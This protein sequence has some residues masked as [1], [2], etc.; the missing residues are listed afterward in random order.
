MHAD[1]SN[2]TPDARHWEEL[3]F[4]APRPMWIYDVN[5]LEFLAVN[6]AAV[7]TYGWSREEFHRMTI[8]DIRPKEDAAR[9][10]IAVAD[11]APYKRSGEWHHLW[12]DGTLRSVEITSHQ[13]EWD[14]R[15]ARLVIAEDVTERNEVEQRLRVMNEKLRAQAALLDMATDAIYVH[16]LDGRVSYWNRSSAEL[17]GWSAEEAVGRNIEELMGLP[18]SDLA[19]GMPALIR[20]GQK[21]GEYRARDRKGS[22]FTLE[23]R[24]TVMYSDDGSPYAILAIATDVTAQRKLESQLLRSQRLESIGTLAGGI[25]HDLNNMLSPIMMSIQLLSE[26][27]TDEGRELLKTIER[28]ARRG[29][30]LVRQVLAFARGMEGERAPVAIAGVIDETQRL[31]RETLPR[32]IRLDI[33]VEPDIPEVIG[34][35]TQLHQV[36]LNLCVNARDAMPEGGV[37]EINAL[38]KQLDAQFAAMARSGKAGT[39]ACIEVT[40]TGGGI[41]REL[42]DRIFDPFFTTKPVGVGTGLGLPTVQ[43]IVRSHGGF[44]NVYSEQG[45]GTTFRVYLPTSAIEQVHEPPA[46]VQS[47]LPRGNGELVLVADDE[48][49][50]REITRQTLE[51]F[52]YR[53]VLASD[54]IEALALF[55]RHG[56]EIALILTDM[57]MPNLDGP[58]LIRAIKSIKPDAVIV[59]AS[60]LGANGG[61]A[62]AAGHGVTQ[63]IPKPYTAETLLVAI[64]AAL[65]SGG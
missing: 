4:S 48:A 27:V 9:L 31:L 22:E 14:R 16:D 44:V 19:A 56:S 6:D 13:M 41:P 17:F 59:A 23:I 42:L 30:D 8:A 5:S 1:D 15:L 33:N 51:A 26:E 21:R 61:V 46:T 11:Y 54:G 58:G 57:M 62:K 43:S 37:I 36:L 3:F 45:K 65:R 32:S 60:G 55:N 38:S 29:A 12:K 49:A 10:A 25:A 63:F 20:Q 40:D 28:S 50:I 53:V 7:H 34:D 39:Y 24:V 52:G 2:R 35:E 64:A 47:S 18:L